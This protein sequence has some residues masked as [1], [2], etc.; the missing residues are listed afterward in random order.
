LKIYI[1]DG[2]PVLDGTPEELARYQRMA[3][4]LAVYDAYQK[5]LKAIADGKPPGGQLEDKPPARRRAPPKKKR[6]DESNG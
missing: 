2:T 6:K 5:L 4:Q 1:V 3:Q